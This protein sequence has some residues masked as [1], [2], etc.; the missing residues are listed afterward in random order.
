MI[1]YGGKSFWWYVKWAAIIVVVYYAMILV[2]GLPLA[3][4]AEPN[5]ELGQTWQ[6]V[7]TAWHRLMHS[8]GVE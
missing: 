4:T 1:A 8:L 3:L 7:K 6:E 5:S 2:V